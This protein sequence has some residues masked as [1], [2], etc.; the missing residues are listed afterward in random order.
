M[1]RSNSMCILSSMLGKVIGVGV[2][3]DVNKTLNS[4]KIPE[5]GD[6]CDYCLYRKLLSEVE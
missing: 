1:K 6:D 3:L 4:K 2:L 5:S